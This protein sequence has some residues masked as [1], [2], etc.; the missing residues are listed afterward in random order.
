M[1]RFSPKEAGHWDVDGSPDRQPHLQAA[2]H[3][4]DD[5]VKLLVVQHGPVLLHVEVQ[6]LGEAVAS[7]P[8][9]HG[10]EHSRQ[11][12]QGNRAA[13]SRG[14]ASAS[15]PPALPA[16]GKPEASGEGGSATAGNGGRNLPREGKPRPGLSVANSPP[17]PNLH[18]GDSALLYAASHG[19]GI[20]QLVWLM[21]QASDL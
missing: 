2:V 14:P 1:L 4:P 8:A 18:S 6:L 7:G 11:E 12:L 13:L 9:L 16:L 19:K 3:H 17:P 21:F 20:Q 10:S 5:E 15:P